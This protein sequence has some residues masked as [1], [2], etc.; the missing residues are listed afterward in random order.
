LT[1]LLSPLL[2]QQPALPFSRPPLR[3]RFSGGIF[4]LEFYG[5]SEIKQIINRSAHIL[6]ISIAEDA[7]DEIAKRSR[8]TPRI[9]NYLLKRCRDFAQVSRVD[10]TKKAVGDALT[11]LEIDARGLSSV[12]RKILETIIH[13]FSGGPVGLGTIATAISEEEATIEEVNEP[14]L[15]QIGFL[16]RTRQGRMATKYSYEHFGMKAPSFQQENLL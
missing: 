8:F 10:L 16:E 9:A 12:D 7:C 15:I 14:Y 1:C 2:P 13:K 5:L 11:L 4:R 3:S 6:E